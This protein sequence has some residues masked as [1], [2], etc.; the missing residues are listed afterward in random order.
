MGCC[1]TGCEGRRH[2]IGPLMGKNRS[3]TLPPPAPQPVR[4]R[5]YHPQRARGRDAAM[6]GYAPQGS[7]QAPFQR[8]HGWGLVLLI[9]R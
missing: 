1:W 9:A 5:A 6:R 7:N 2:K 8:T 4:S 3:R